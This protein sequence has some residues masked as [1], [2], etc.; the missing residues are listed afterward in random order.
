[1]SGVNFSPDLSQSAARAPPERTSQFACSC[2]RERFSRTL[3]RSP[4]ASGKD[5]W[6][7]ECRMVAAEVM[8]RREMPST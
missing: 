3:R 7:G 8:R 4:L 2:A 6:D 1:M 5:G